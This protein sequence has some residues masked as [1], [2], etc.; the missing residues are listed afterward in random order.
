MKCV[1][2]REGPVE[3]NGLM[4]LIVQETKRQLILAEGKGEVE[5][6]SLLFQR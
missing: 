3:L 1:G 6:Q 2:V 4:K 5:G